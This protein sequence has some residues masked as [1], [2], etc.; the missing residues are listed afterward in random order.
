MSISFNGLGSG[1]AVSDIVDALVNAEQAPAEA[2]LNTKEANLTTD[3]SAVGALKSALE[4]VQTS[5]EALGDS[6][7]YQQRSTS[8]TDD[9]ISISAD[10]NAQPGSYN[11]K[12]DALA[13]A[14]KLSSPAFAADEAIGA[15]V[16]TI[17]SGTNSFST[18]LSATNTLEDLRDQINNG[19][20]T[21][22]D[23]NDSVVATIVTSDTGQHLVLTS[24][25]T[26]E[27]NA[28]TISVQDDDGN[29]TDTGGLSRLAYDV[30]DAD[31]ANHTTN[32]TEVNAA[33]NAQ[34]TIDGALTVSSN[35]NEFS[36][37][38][39][40]V[41]INVKKLH[42]IDDD[43]SD[44]SVTENNNNI[45]TGLNSFISS[46]NELLE[47]SNTLGASGEDGVGVMAGDSLL[48]GVM[49]KLRDTI[50]DS[51]NVGGSSLSLS[52]LGVTTDRYGVLSLDSDTLNDQI[53]SDVSLVQQF[54]VGSNDDGFA[55]SFD[56]L[57]SFYTDSDGIIQNRIDSKTNQLDDLDDQRE[58][59][60]SKMESLSA[61][62]YS[63]YNAMDLLVASLNNTSS[64]VQAQ[65]ENMPGVVRQSN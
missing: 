38:I 39:D 14:H 26:G 22:N 55:Q 18:V 2:R 6:D 23:S 17:G 11:V 10:E 37:V 13:Q 35:T 20:F 5:M 54:F 29:N 46:Y 7:K 12:V 65:L 4:K 51:V 57:V 32:L 40:G 27:D 15:G 36:N 58:S 48:R 49:S 63:Q 52:Q 9:F 53:K 64:Y 31:P 3:I 61:R 28:I 19:P 24:K 42:D 30:S 47:L 1:L 50:T 41:D 33:Q 60:T 43:I 34:I 62:L 21:D 44:I 25:E 56:D 16:I 45:K 8:G 59:L